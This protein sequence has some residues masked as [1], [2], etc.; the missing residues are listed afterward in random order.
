MSAFFFIFHLV[1][2]VL[3]SVFLLLNIEQSVLLIIYFFTGVASSIFI[4]LVVVFAAF[5]KFGLFDPSLIAQK[6]GIVHE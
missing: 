5:Y 3:L 1:T 2:Y 4:S 6:I